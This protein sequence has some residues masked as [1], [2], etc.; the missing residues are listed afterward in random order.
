[1]SRYDN[2]KIKRY[3]DILR[4][5]S[6]IYQKVPESNDDMYVITQIGD[7]L[8]SLANEYYGSSN[9]WWFIAHVNNLNSMNIEPGTR[10]RI[11]FDL[12]KAKDVL[13]KS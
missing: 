12:D 10:L 9:L 11:S 13:D 1:M 6:T 8:D 3:N 2:T 5:R 7:R 4:Y